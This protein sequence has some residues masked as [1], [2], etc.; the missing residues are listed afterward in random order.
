[1]KNIP[2]YALL[3]KLSYKLT[4]RIS[5]VIFFLDVALIS[6]FTFGLLL[7]VVSILKNI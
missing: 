1:M 3:T 7:M 4:N 6:L 5:P 2:S